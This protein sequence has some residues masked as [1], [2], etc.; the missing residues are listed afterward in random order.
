LSVS[1]DNLSPSSP[2][3]PLQKS[4]T[5]ALV[6][7]LIITTAAKSLEIE[8]QSVHPEL[9]LGANGKN[10]A[11]FTVRA[12]A[13]ADFQDQVEAVL[14]WKRTSVTLLVMVVF[15]IA[16]LFPAL[17]I[18]APFAL[19][20]NII[21]S[22]YFYRAKRIAMANGKP[23]STLP[24]EPS[25]IVKFGSAAH[26]RNL[27]FIQNSMGMFADTFDA[28]RLQLTHLDW[29][30]EQHTM[31]VLKYVLL[32]WLGLGITLIFV[33]WN[34]LLMLGGWGAFTA[35]TAVARAA[36]DVIMPR[37]L[38]VLKVR[39]EKVRQ[40]FGKPGLENA[41]EGRAEADLALKKSKTVI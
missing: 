9:S 33:P 5:S 32:G 25:P 11:R 31:E 40:R 20:T 26:R 39:Y 36:A 4:A 8:R 13:L 15:T 16:C 14:L 38:E 27:T 28:V 24:P 23:L 29:N 21:I 41:R 2:R 18:M 12:G 19:I 6:Q 30:D 3:S 1:T 10:F 17:I 34:Y 35:N 22:N 37:L 7:D